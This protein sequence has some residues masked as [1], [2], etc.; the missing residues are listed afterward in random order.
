MENNLEYVVVYNN[1]DDNF[2]EAEKFFN[3]KESAIKFAEYISE[4]DPDSYPQV[5][6]EYGQV[7]WEF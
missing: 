2:R 6:D 7:V 1:P 3:N 5:I 4:Y